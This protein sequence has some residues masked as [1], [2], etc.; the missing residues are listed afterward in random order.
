MLDLL[1]KIAV[2]KDLNSAVW[3]FTSN[4]HKSQH[5]RIIS[6]ENRIQRLKNKELDYLH[7]VDFIPEI[8]ELN[9]E[10]FLDKV[11]IDQLNVK[12]VLMGSNA[13]LGKDRH[14]RAAD[15]KSLAASKGVQVVLFDLLK[16]DEKVVSSSS[17]RIAINS[18]DFKGAGSM[19]GYPWF[20]EGTVVDG[21]KMGRT[22]GF[23]TA[24]ILMEGI[25]VPPIGVYACTVNCDK[26]NLHNLSAIVNIGKR[27][28][29]SEEDDIV[30]EVH[31]PNWS[32]DL[33]K[34]TLSISKFKF[35]RAEQ[36]FESIDE[37]KKQIESDIRTSI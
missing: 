19:L 4:H 36:K 24:N 1:L 2:E 6:E 10:E 16:V 21:N 12:V 3:S 34:H 22:I 5:F 31:I 23:P 20:I 8:S 14:C 13:Q 9:A 15:F 33:Y 35:I 37:L 25:V 27:P 26:L 11:L 17:I 30:V 29:L 7:N 32:G 28:T 18:G